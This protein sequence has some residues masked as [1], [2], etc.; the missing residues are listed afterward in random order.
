M[1]EPHTVVQIAVSAA[2]ADTERS[3]S[4]HRLRADQPFSVKRVSCRLDNL[5]RRRLTTMLLLMRRPTSNHI[6]I[7]TNDNCRRVPWRVL[8]NGRW[9]LMTDEAYLPTG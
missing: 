3:R 7:Q 6:I 9:E 8:L 1:P 4:A 5:H 2:E